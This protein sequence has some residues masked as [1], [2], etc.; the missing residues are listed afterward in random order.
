MKKVVVVTLYTKHL[1]I[2][3]TL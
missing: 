3:W 2:N 1:L